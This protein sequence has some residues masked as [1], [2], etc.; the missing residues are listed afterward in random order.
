[1]SLIR[2][3]ANFFP[4]RARELGQ[5]LFDSGC[6]DL[7]RASPTTARAEVSGDSF[8]E[9]EFA[10]EN[11]E[12]LAECCCDEA[13]GGLL[14]GHLYATLLACEAQ[15]ELRKAASR[16][17]RKHA[18]IRHAAASPLGEQRRERAVPSS[19]LPDCEG[20]STRRST[21]TQ[22]SPNLPE[23][24]VDR[25]AGRPLLPEDPSRRLAYAIDWPLTRSENRLAVTI[26][27]QASKDGR[28]GAPRTCTQLP[29]ELIA[30]DVDKQIAK[31]IRTCSYKDGSYVADAAIE[32]A[33]LE[34]VL[35]SDRAFVI[36]KPRTAPVPFDVVAELG[37]LSFAFLEDQP[38]E[39]RLRNTL[40]VEGEAVSLNQPTVLLESGYLLFVD[41]AVALT[42]DQ[43]FWLE[44]TLY[45]PAV[46]T[47]RTLGKLAAETQIRTRIPARSFPAEFQ[48]QQ[49]TPKPTGQLFVRTAH[50]KFRGKE[51]LHAELGFNY[52]GTEFRDGDE[53]M[54][55]TN[56]HDRITINRDLGAEE[57]L[58]QKL[59]EVGF[60]YQ[61]VG[62][63]EELGWKLLPAD[64]PKA[65]EALVLDD[66]LVTAEGKTYPKPTEKKASI[67]YKTNWFELDGSVA[68]GDKEV[69]FPELL[70]L[71]ASGES[72][73]VLDDGTCGVLP[74][75]WLRNFTVLTEIG[76]VEDDLIKFSRAQYI[77]VDQL[78]QEQAE[79][80]K[81]ERCQ[82]QEAAIKA[83]TGIK[84]MDAPDCFQGTLRDYQR[85]GL[86]W[87]L[88][89]Q[90]L[91]LGIC[92]A[93]DMGLGKTVQIL[94]LLASQPSGGRPSLIVLPKS[95]VFN[96]QAEAAKF[97]PNLKV[98]VYTGASRKSKVVE[99]AKTDLILT[100]YGTVRRDALTLK[101]HAFHYCI[102]DE[103]QAI[104]N[105]DSQTA[106]A[107]RL[108]QASHRI[109]MTGT[110]IENNLAE[111]LSQFEFMNPR[112]LG[113]LPAFKN[114]AEST[115]LDDEQLA[116]LQRAIAPFFL[117]R[118]KEAVAKD[119]PEKTVQVLYC[120]LDDAE[121]KRY[122]ELRDHFRRE[123]IADKAA[124][125]HKKPKRPIFQALLRLRQAA[126]HP[127]LPNPDFLA[128]TSSKQE[129]VR[130]RIKELIAEHHKVLIFSQFTTFLGIIKEDLEAL[131]V[132]YAYLDGQTS[133]R[134]A[135]V[136]QF[137]TDP[138]TKA[139]LISLK[140]G[141]V[142][143]NLTAADYVFL[144][145][146]WWN[147]AIEAQAIDRAYRIGQ[148]RHV[149]AYKVIAKDTIEEKVLELQQ[150]KQDL[151]EAVFSGDSAQA[152]RSLTRDDL[153]YLLS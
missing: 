4:D 70:K 61:D 150:Q 103:S 12:L 1:L 95:L 33:L 28:W 48:F 128:A 65:V 51:Q 23:L 143:L 82:E 105:Y 5:S 108:L 58:R 26:C 59:R 115:N 29:D 123:F 72:I 121:R 151:A 127:G 126:C 21:V 62:M 153:E 2:K 124:E 44:R 129:L 81:D 83:F 19:S 35:K 8:H 139:F 40:K 94:A 34:S 88:Q 90:E 11:N 39:Y 50:F 24:T 101:E 49:V 20:G 64:L 68:F 109:C 46:Y 52:N 148:Q 145:D 9:T 76:L 135:Q 132:T 87:M 15:G 141:G 57:A 114:V 91:Q 36:G 142:G 30:N 149:F 131:N 84:P 54:T 100:T 116:S 122:D 66:W 60:R 152:I 71:V 133:D 74:T 118:T 136:K 138:N 45:A 97:A 17:T 77:L 107:V 86:G 110:P 13:G 75:E 96:W 27:W 37:K 130:D 42:E 43:Y 56:P 119:L 80:H 111:L 10:V 144:L 104:K 18:R 117:R 63:R 55:A 7:Y 98:L 6:V 3:F 134:D 112:L 47:P 147:P 31:A 14:C 85:D 53:R 146:P 73:V 22:G 38:G 137:Q 78:L 69:Q 16:S 67:S 125:K 99:F 32:G 41:D 113:R 92:L 93:D 79:L 25:G 89:M 102:L 140:A 120:D 106:K